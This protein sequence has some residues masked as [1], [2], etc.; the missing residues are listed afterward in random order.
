MKKQ[1]QDPNLTIEHFEDDI[2][3]LSIGDGE[4][5]DG[6]FSSSQDKDT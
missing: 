4:H 5:D 3:C 2:I 1:F 6:T